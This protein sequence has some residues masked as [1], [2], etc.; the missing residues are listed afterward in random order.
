MLELPETVVQDLL[1]MV[2]QVLA[3]VE[4]NQVTQELVD[5]VEMGAPPPILL[6]EEVQE[7]QE[8]LEMMVLVQVKLGLVVLEVLVDLEE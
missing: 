2:E 6:R 8:V 3:V 7:M 5:P 4:L 1:L